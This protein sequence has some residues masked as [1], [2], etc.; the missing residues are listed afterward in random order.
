MPER[1]GASQADL[2]AAARRAGYQN[3]AQMKAR[4]DLEARMQQQQRQPRAMDFGERMTQNFERAKQNVLS[5]HPAT[6]LDYARK[7]IE[8]ATKPRGRSS[9][10]A[11]NVH[12]RTVERQR[13]RGQ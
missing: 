9:G 10:V 3:Y 1:Q 2:D 12:E 8:D 11:P 13:R 5:L 6:L 7:K 4:Q